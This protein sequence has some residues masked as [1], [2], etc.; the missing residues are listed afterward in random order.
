[1]SMICDITNKPLLAHYSELTSVMW[2]L[3]A[4]SAHTLRM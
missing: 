3:K 1:M 4:P 2:K